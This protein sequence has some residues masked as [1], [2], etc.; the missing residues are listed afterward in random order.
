MKE[1]RKPLTAILVEATA[2][3]LAALFTYTAVS[4][5]YDWKATKTAL[6]NQVIPDWSKEILLYGLPGIEILVS[7]LLLLPRFRKMGFMLSLLL[8]S[9]FTGYVGWIWLGWA[10]KVPCSCG[11][12]LESMDWGT[13]LVFNLVFLGI[14]ILGYWFMGKAEG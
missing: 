11:G 2:W 3:L 10:P 1:S 7:I 6:F 4:K 5:V 12:V 14:S 8:M 13:H 9:L